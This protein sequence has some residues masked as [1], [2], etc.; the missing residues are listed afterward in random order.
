MKMIETIANS[1]GR[2]WMVHPE[3]VFL[4]HCVVH[5]IMEYDGVY[6]IM[7]KSGL[8][9]PNL[10]R[11]RITFEIHYGEC[12]DPKVFDVYD[13]YIRIKRC[14]LRRQWM[15]RPM[16]ATPDDVQYVGGWFEFEGELDHCPWLLVGR[17]RLK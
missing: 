5:R 1:S 14:K 3:V 9:D 15:Q 10:F 17:G 12:T 11:G 13:E 8:V 4:P 2:L 6:R 7:I 16:A